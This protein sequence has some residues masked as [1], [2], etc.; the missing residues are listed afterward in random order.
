MKNFSNRETVSAVNPETASYLPSISTDYGPV[1]FP[2][3]RIRS[4]NLFSYKSGRICGVTAANR[5]IRSNSSQTALRFAPVFPRLSLARDKTRHPCRFL[6]LEFA[7]GKLRLSAVGG[8]PDLSAIPGAALPG[9][10]SALNF[11][12][13]KTQAIIATGLRA[14]PDNNPGKPLT[15]RGS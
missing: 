1:K 12:F 2:E 8:E 14:G 10:F 15:G 13:A 11:C 5:A 6:S 4:F 3:T 7:C 9:I